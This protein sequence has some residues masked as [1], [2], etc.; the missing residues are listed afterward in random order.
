[1]PSV[2]LNGAFL[3]RDDARISAFDAGLQHGVGLFETMLAV[4]RNDGREV[5]DLDA[6]LDRLALSARELRLTE[7]LRVD[8]L[9]DAVLHTVSRAGEEEDAGRLRV[10]LTIT[11]GDLNLLQN[12]RTSESKTGETQQQ[13]TL[14]ISAT[15]ATEYPAEMF[16]KGVLVSIADWKANPLDPM[17]GHKTINYWARLRE[18]QTAAA[19][20]AAEAL[21]FQ[22][23]NHLAGGCVSNALLVRDGAVISPI[24]RTEEVR[25]AGAED[26]PGS[27][28]AA[29][30]PSP[31]LPGITRRWA[32]DWAQGEG[33]TIERRALTIHD[34][35]AADELLLTNSSWGVLPVVAVE[36]HVV[37]AG[38]PGEVGRALTAAWRERLI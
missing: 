26:Q 17:Q 34:I 24:C 4:A 14:L 10:R 37:G 6:H 3:E 2:F 32:L 15:R 22:V 7:R 21:I 8:A 36:S 31:I 27:S 29:I 23:T 9:R 38:R 33:R 25:A 16:E 1:M 13:P 20:N 35:L 11:G 12:S 18:L 30:L 19:K 5:L 28:G